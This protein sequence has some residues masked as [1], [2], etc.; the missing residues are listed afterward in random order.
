VGKVDRRHLMGSLPNLESINIV[1]GNRI[2]FRTKMETY[3][4]QA[5][6]DFSTRTADEFDPGV[7]ERIPSMEIKNLTPRS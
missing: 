3:D 6:E 5:P 1:N 7:R 4:Y 2:N